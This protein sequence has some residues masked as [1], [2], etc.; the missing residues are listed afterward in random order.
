MSLPTP[1]ELARE[2]ESLCGATCDHI[3]NYSSKPCLICLAACIRADREAVLEEA[4]SEGAIAGGIAVDSAYHE[5][6]WRGLS[7]D[8][9]NAVGDA[10]RGGVRS[11]LCPEPK[12]DADV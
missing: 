1:E 5:Q 8:V 4:A 7:D 11:R 2:I 3:I 10:I 9:E 12:G 6:R